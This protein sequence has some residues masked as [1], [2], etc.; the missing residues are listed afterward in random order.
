MKYEE[1]SC[2][3]LQVEQKEEL[4]RIGYFEVIPTAESL[5]RNN[6]CNIEANAQLISLRIVSPGV[7][8]HRILLPD[9]KQRAE[10]LN[11]CFS[12]FTIDK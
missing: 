3:K 5:L 11:A 2:C 7:F 6:R 4:F 12:T 8:R 1:W 10:I 9:F